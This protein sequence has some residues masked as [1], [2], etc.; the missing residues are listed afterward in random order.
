MSTL[1]LEIVTPER[2]VYSKDVNMVI[3]RGVEGEMGILPNHVPTVTPLKIS[4][5]TAKI[6]SNYE[7][8]AVSGGFAEVRHEKVVILAESAELPGEIDVDRA[9]L[10]KKRAEERIRNRNK[11]TVDHHRAELALQRALNRLNTRG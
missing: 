1:L 11:E 7:N 6:G 8:I 3:I 9:E 5:V 4:A 10:A 2:T